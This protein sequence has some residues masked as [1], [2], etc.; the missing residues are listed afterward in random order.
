MLT[1]DGGDARLERELLQDQ[2]LH[3]VRVLDEIEFAVLACYR[4]RETN[5]CGELVDQMRLAV[6]HN[7][8]ILS[9]V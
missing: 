4:P 8:T 2:V 1:G 5:A 7:D 3:G 6:K 9:E